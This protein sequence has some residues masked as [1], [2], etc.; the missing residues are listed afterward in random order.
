MSDGVEERYKHDDPDEVEDTEVKEYVPPEECGMNDL[1]DKDEE[2]Y[3]A[4]CQKDL[5]EQL[6]EGNPVY[7]LTNQDMVCTKRCMMEYML[8]YILERVVVQE[9]AMGI[10]TEQEEKKENEVSLL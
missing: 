7:Y 3:C 6:D 8:N 10:E 5:R 4:N 2:V 9:E 1:V